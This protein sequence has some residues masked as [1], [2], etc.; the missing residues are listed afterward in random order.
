MPRYRQPTD[1][2]LAEL[3]AQQATLWTLAMKRGRTVDRTAVE[4]RR[5]GQ[6]VK[7][8]AEAYAT[9]PPPSGSARDIRLRALLSRARLADLADLSPKTVLRAERASEGEHVEVRPQTWRALAAGLSRASGARIR[10][11]DIRPPRAR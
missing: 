3:E 1:E 9:D 4:A 2:R 5:A 8:A 11:R 7:V 10:V 6:M